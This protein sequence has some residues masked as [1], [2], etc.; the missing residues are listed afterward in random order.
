[1]IKS[2]LAGDVSI[3]RAKPCVPKHKCSVCDDTWVSVNK[4]SCSACL[5]KVYEQAYAAKQ[6]LKA[7]ALKQERSIRFCEECKTTLRVGT[8]GARRWCADCSAERAAERARQASREQQK[9]RAE[10]AA[11]K[12]KK[13]KLTKVVPLEPTEAMLSAFHTAIERWHK[14]E[15]T[16][17][18]VYKAMLAVTP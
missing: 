6:K 9:V 2:W 7:Q 3:T 12:P 10:K 17:A 1:M 13:I 14:E 16:D 15:G 11:K 4:T 8:H 5:T 18:D